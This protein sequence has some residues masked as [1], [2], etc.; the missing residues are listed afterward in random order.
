M[1]VE[2]VSACEHEYDGKKFS[3]GERFDVEPGHV[4]LLLLLQRIKPEE[5]E[6]GY[7]PPEIEEI[8]TDQNLSVKVKKN[9]RTRNV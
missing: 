5:G 7:V 2:R 3:A 8:Q 4:G 1:R 6:A 9:G